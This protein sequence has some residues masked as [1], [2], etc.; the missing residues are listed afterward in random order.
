M[1]IVLETDNELDE[2]SGGPEMSD[3]DDV[4]SEIEV[5][6]ERL[7][8]CDVTDEVTSSKEAV[9]E[10]ISAA[11]EAKVRLEEHSTRLAVEIRVPVSWKPASCPAIF[12]T[13]QC[14]T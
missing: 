3:I 13:Y 8:H 9:I 5:D 10:V 6:K 4:R 14:Q 7:G 1:F 2:W 11:L 12:L